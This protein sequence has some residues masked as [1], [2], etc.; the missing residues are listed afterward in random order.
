MASDPRLL[1][2]IALVVIHLC[3]A[4]TSS[5]SSVSPS[6]VATDLAPLPETQTSILPGPYSIAI[7]PFDDLTDNPALAWLRH[8]FVEMLTTDLAAFSSL[9]VVARQALEDVLR[10]QW[11]QHRG[12]SSEWPAVRVGRLVGAR[13]LLKGSYHLDHVRL[14]L[15]VH[16][17]DSEQGT[18]ARSARV[19]GESEDIP[20]LERRLAKQIGM[21]FRAQQ[22]RHAQ[23]KDTSELLPSEDTAATFNDPFAPA[24]DV[25]LSHE[26]LAPSRYS[27]PL[28]TTGSLLYL[29]RIQRRREMAVALADH[30]W[31]SSMTI[32]LGSMTYRT[33]SFGEGT[34][35][36]MPVLVLAVTAHVD[37]SYLETMHTRA[38]WIVATARP[39][40]SWLRLVWQDADAGAQTLFQSRMLE[41]RRLFVR[42][43]NAKGVV[44]AASS[45]WEWR[46][47][48]YVQ[49]QGS[50]VALRIDHPLV[51][52]E[53]YFPMVKRAKEG[54]ALSF[55]AVIVRVPRE[56]RIIKVEP[57][58]PSDD[59]VALPPSTIE[60]MTAG[61]QDWWQKKWK[62]YIWE[63]IP[64]SGYLPSNRRSAVLIVSGIQNRV[65]RVR[66]LRPFS[67]PLLVQ[68]IERLSEELVGT[69]LSTCEP[70][71]NRSSQS[72][73]FR[74]QLDVIKDVHALGLG[75]SGAP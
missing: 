21:W 19:V 7:F 70:D 72:M 17:I 31:M 60:T 69:C 11:L 24:D 40:S 38:K 57:V 27:H 13:Y 25:N 58:E 36:V 12:I 44:V 30:V 49:K 41:P 52:G 68:E 54:R 23:L 73:A 35:L 43:R 28:M 14:V 46:M 62:P 67:E 26:S 51:A 2:F 32:T 1:P 53:A 10:E 71:G 3:Y 39:G 64:V 15:D 20:E 63:S 18:V 37:L 34:Y 65:Y 47:D 55:D 33:L 16:L 56:R 8:G 22:R 66:V 45:P 4:C 74:V 42:A 59:H 75:G 61:L 29:D 6:D 5:S 9:R 48:R 50:G